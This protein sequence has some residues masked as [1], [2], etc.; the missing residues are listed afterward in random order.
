MYIGSYVSAWSRST[1]ICYFCVVI[2]IFQACLVS[3]QTVQV[4]IQTLV[5]FELTLDRLA[6]DAVALGWG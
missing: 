4:N 3:A 6:L 5:L 2:W 1:E